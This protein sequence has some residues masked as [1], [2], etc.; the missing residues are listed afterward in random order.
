MQKIKKGDE[1]IVL[2]GKD[3]GAIGK[4]LK[5]LPK[6]SKVLVE[7]VG[8]VKKHVKPNPNLQRPGQIMEIEKPVHISN[9]ALYD[10]TTGKAGKVGFKFLEDG[11]KVRYFKST[12]EVIDA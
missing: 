8:I 3:K 9:V 2:A 7:G 1:V 11:T 6:L 4:V 10:A 12:K 5:V